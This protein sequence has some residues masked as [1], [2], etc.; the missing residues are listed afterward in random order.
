M[1]SLTDEE[2]IDKLIPLMN[3]ERS[4]DMIVFLHIGR[5]LINI[6]DGSD[7]ALTL[8][9]SF[10]MKEIIPLCDE[11]WSIL[12][13]ER[14]ITRTSMKIGDFLTLIPDIDISSIYSVKCILKHIGEFS[15]E[16]SRMIK[17]LDL[18][19]Q[20]NLPILL[21]KRINVRILDRYKYRY[22]IRIIEKWISKDNPKEYRELLN[23]S[24]YVDDSV[25]DNLFGTLVWADVQRSIIMGDNTTSTI[26]GLLRLLRSSIGCV[27]DGKGFFVMNGVNNISICTESQFLS[28]CSRIKVRKLKNIGLDTIIVDFMIYFMY[29]DIT[30]YPG[31]TDGD[32]LNLFRQYEA[33]E[34]SNIYQPGIDKIISHIRDTLCNNDINIYN[35]VIDW[36]SYLVQNPEKPGTVLMM[37]GR[38]GVGKT[39]FWEWFADSIVGMHNSFIAATLSDITSRFNGHI[40]SKRFILINECKGTSKHDHEY[41][42]TLITDNYVRLERK[43][44]DLIQIN[45]SHCIVITSNQRDHHFIDE[46]DRRFLVVECSRDKKSNNYFSELSMMLSNYRDD[47]FTYLRRRDISSFIPSIIPET[48][49][50]EDIKEINIHPV[51]LFLREYR[52]TDWLMGS[53][54]YN[55]YTEWCVKSG[56]QP[57]ASNKFKIYSENMI[58]TKKSNKGVY[59]MHTQFD[60]TN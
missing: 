26:G 58:D 10:C 33:R 24:N 51:Q 8:W 52:W 53:I 34:I 45:S 40:A 23:V 12:T 59:Y 15:E 32:I 27:K 48:S 31:I 36:M 44:Q 6:F 9:K 39:I 1:V 35:Y 46:H 56:I 22:D 43:G 5:T 2:K 37:I 57:V 49:I 4:R 21:D 13:N 42:K 41:L 19:K 50:K 3:K 20:D 7:D 30:Y 29:R 25:Y 16:T 17:R 14:L 18:D 47:F 38:P 54:V 11:Y 55:D 28:M 60:N